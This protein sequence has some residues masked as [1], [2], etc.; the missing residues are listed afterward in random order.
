MLGY[1]NTWSATKAFIKAKGFDPVAR[2]AD[3]F[4]TAWGSAEA[5]RTVWWELTFKMG[6]VV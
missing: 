2:L 3:E 4:A 5:E 6:R 1:M